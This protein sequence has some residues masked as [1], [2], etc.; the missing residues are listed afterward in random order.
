MALGKVGLS[1][2]IL[3]FFACTF[4]A[5]LETALSSGYTVAQ[6]FGWPWGK[7]VAPRKAA[8]FHLVV[9]AC[10]VV[11]VLV[12]VTAIDPIKVTEYSIVLSAAALPLT[13]F[14]ILVVANDRTYMHEHA[15][16]RVQNV[17]ASVYFVI[18]VVVAVATI[19]LMIATKA[20][21]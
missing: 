6:Y 14:P 8:R 21:A 19:P 4:G 1:A 7:L 17:I 11:A 15:N 12:G 9:L 2:V 18:L 3:G 16:G 20:G 10:T 5:A 13:Y